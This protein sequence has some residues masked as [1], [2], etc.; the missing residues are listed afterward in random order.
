MCPQTGVPTEGGPP[1]RPLV[2]T[3][4]RGHS[5]RGRGL[6]LTLA[7]STTSATRNWPLAVVFLESLTNFELKLTPVP[8]PTVITIT[9]SAS[10][11]RNM[12]NP[13]GSDV[14]NS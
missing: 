5:Y 14:V 11:N 10:F 8:P 4:V 6:I 7:A 1:G 9:V 3:P 12:T 13:T 2:G